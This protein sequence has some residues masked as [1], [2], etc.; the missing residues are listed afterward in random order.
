M[1]NNIKQDQTRT[2]RDFKSADYNIIN[3]K[4]SSFLNSWRV[5]FDG[6]LTLEEVY[7]HF[8]SFLTKTIDEHVPLRLC[9]R[10]SFK[11]P[12]HIMKLLKEKLS[13]YKRYKLNKSLHEDYK[14][15]SKQYDAAV[16]SMHDLRENNIC[17]NPSSRKFRNFYKRKMKATS[18]IPP[19]Y[20]SDNKVN[21]SNLEKANL[22]NSCFHKVFQ[23]DDGKTLNIDYKT[24]QAMGTVSI[25]ISDVLNALASLKDKI[26]KTPETI[27]SYF[28]KRTSASIAPFLVSFFNSSLYH[29][30]IPSQWKSAIVTAIFKKGDQSK[31]G[32]SRP[33]SLTSSISRVFEIIL[34]NKILSHFTTSNLFSQNQFGFL[35][36]R[37]SCSQIMTSLHEWYQNF[38]NK[39]TT[40]IIYTDIQKAF[41][42]VNYRKLILI[43][44]SYRL[45]P[46]LIN[47]I[48]N[49]LSQRNQVVQ[50]QDSVSSSCPIFSGIPQGSILGPLLFLIYINSIDV[51]E[52]P[53][54]DSGGLRLFAD[55][56]KF[57]STNSSNLQAS[58]HHFSKWLDEHQLRLAPEK[59]SVLT[60]SLSEPNPSFFLNNTQISSS[61]FIRDLGII[62]SDNLKW[63]K[64]I[65][66][67]YRNASTSAYQI[68]RFSK[69][70]NIWT[71]IKLF[72]TYIRPKLEFNTPLWSPHLTKDITRIEK[73]QRTFTRYVFKKCNLPYSSYSDR[74]NQINLQSLEYRRISFD[75]IFL[76]KII[77]NLAGIKFSN[78]FIFIE[79]PYT[80]RSKKIKIKPKYESS[81][82]VWQH[83]FFSRAPRLWNSL[84]D[85]ITDSEN[86]SCFKYRLNK[87]DLNSITKLIF[88]K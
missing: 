46:N 39:K 3:S 31:P 1:Q 5:P 43:L 75:L 21:I 83:S 38:C 50:I 70:R 59:C 10:K 26:T 22:L 49:F 42:S 80:L 87:F 36:L 62:I 4:I 66:Y 40:H 72:K 19:L 7:N 12:K 8:I 13:L 53:I 37:S 64:H 55:D 74:L 65:D 20:D 84:P 51:C 28:L 76:Y 35:P 32:N 29:N 17:R 78:Y 27:P 61:K 86:L 79:T 63:E 48:S 18:T 81:I 88:T 14:L 54:K 52:A 6:S 69:T 25:E 56:A 41:D 16:K 77:N 33:I 11:P 60:L 15:K 44:E 85:K 45:E 71:L 23:Q 58:L 68:S 73:V 82:P 24:D 47:W 34:Y 67:I 57:F 2:Y 9:K 30:F